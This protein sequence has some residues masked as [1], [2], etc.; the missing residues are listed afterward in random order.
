M[1]QVKAAIVLV[2]VAAAIVFAI[3][4]VAIVEVQFLV[5]SFSMSRALLIVALL[6]VGIVV[7]F[8]ISSLLALKRK[9]Q[10]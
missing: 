4:N 7:G 3:Q 8:I 6:A 1:R 2:L 9:R 10:A 5:W